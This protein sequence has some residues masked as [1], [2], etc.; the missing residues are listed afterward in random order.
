MAQR[1][2]LHW[3]Q[4][5]TEFEGGASAHKL[6]D[7][8]GVSYRTLLHHLLDS[9]RQGLIKDAS[10]GRLLSDRSH[11]DFADNPE[12]R[13][14]AVLGCMNGELKQTTLL[15]LDRSPLTKGGIRRR[16]EDLTDAPLPVYSTYNDY[17]VQ[18]HVPAGL[19]IH[20]VFGR[21]LKLHHSAFRLTK[22]GVTYGQ[23]I[24]AFSLRYAVDHNLSFYEFLG[25]ATTAGESRAPYN[26]ARIL[27]LIAEGHN[28]IVNLEEALGLD[29]T[30]V[31]YHLRH[32]QSL[33]FLCYR[34]L[35]LQQGPK[36][37]AWVGG[38]APQ[39]A[40]AIWGRRQ[41]TVAVADWLY[42]HR[43][44]HQLL[45]AH[46]LNHRHIQDI[47]KVLVGLVR[48]GLVSTEFES[49]R[50]SEVTLSEKGK[51]VTEYVRAVR[52]ALRDGK[53]LRRMTTL[54]RRFGKNEG[55]FARYVDA[56]VKLHLA[57]SPMSLARTAGER[58]IELV[59]FI[60]SFQDEHK[61]AP[62][63]SE[64]MRGLGWNHGTLQPYLNVLIRKGRLKKMSKG[65]EVRYCLGKQGGQRR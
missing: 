16:L 7:Q 5:L 12:V 33:G 56:A 62:R 47:S 17:C 26:R 44:G 50:R 8:Y 34:S 53:E 61:T 3:Q 14:E 22:A 24:A 59:Q 10:L 13:L 41:L 40:K 9:H 30:N 60:K 1:A 4:I 51:S 54:L 21:G 64:M 19:V 63:P 42:A 2:G 65:G 6:R 31:T 18:S 11:Y 36:L 57:I 58:E 49:V 28:E 27:E 15:V 52:G 20:E 39:E 32:L 29:H 45:I 35:D 23:P 43:V 55:E 48:Q 37:Y 38:R 25:P 46:E